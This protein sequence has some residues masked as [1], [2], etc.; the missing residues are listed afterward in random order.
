MIQITHEK[1]KFNP[2]ESLSLRKSSMTKHK[3]E[4]SWV[5]TTMSRIYE[6]DRVINRT[7]FD[8]SSYYE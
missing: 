3:L 8:N 7:N 1:E 5:E 2:N 6:K 4:N